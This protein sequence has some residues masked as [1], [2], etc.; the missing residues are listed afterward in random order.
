[1]IK[2]LSNFFCSDFTNEAIG[3][4]QCLPG[5][6]IDVEAVYYQNIYIQSTENS[7]DG[8]ILEEIHLTLE[9]SYL[10]QVVY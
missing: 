8:I 6:R 5:S 2:L 1:M 9:V 4:C 10:N 7:S 3:L